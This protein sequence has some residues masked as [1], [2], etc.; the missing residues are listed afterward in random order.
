MFIKYFSREIHY[1]ILNT[2]VFFKTEHFYNMYY[3]NYSGPVS[4][5]FSSCIH[6][7]KNIVYQ[8]NWQRF[9]RRRQKIITDL[10]YAPG[11][12]L[13]KCKSYFNLHFVNL[14][15]EVHDGTHTV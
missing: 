14:R 15:L 9:F 2:I 5:A 11:N 12:I 1:Q 7:K 4:D 8:L 6:K 10:V 3:F 13:Q